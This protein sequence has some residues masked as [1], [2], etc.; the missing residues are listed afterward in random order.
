[1]PAFCTG[2]IKPIRYGE[3]LILRD[4]ARVLGLGAS[5]ALPKRAI[6][7]GSRIAKMEGQQNIKG[8]EKY[9]KPNTNLD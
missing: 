4:V 3:K 9:R 2:D 8:S 7:F 1:M 6:Q 5:S